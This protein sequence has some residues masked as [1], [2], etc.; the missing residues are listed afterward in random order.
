MA[1]TAECI[2]HLG[3]E[4]TATDIQHMLSPHCE[5]TGAFYLRALAV[6]QM[7]WLMLSPRNSLC[8]PGFGALMVLS[9]N[10]GESQQIVEHLGSVTAHQP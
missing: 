3:N 1:R 9:Q 8:F 10:L 6:L 5:T 2:L 7:H 4:A